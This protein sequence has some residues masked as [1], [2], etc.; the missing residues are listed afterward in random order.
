MTLRYAAAACQ[1][2]L[3]NPLDRHQMSANPNENTW[4][5]YGVHSS[6]HDLAGYDEPLFPAADTPIGRI[7]PGERSVVAPID[8]SALRHERAT[9]RGHQMLSHLRPEAYPVYSAHQ[10]PPALAGAPEARLSYE[11]NLELIETAKQHLAGGAARNP[12]A[13]KRPQR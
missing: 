6:P 12:P 10:Y 7:G 4:I 11:R 8:I 3:A 5:P 2:D 13:G 1:T 9:R